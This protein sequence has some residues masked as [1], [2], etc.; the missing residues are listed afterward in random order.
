MVKYSSKGIWFSA[1]SSI[2]YMYI[3][4]ICLNG[5]ICQQIYN[6][7]NNLILLKCIVIFFILIKTHNYKKKNII[8]YDNNRNFFNNKMTFKIKLKYKFH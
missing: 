5:T 6:Y 3:V 7:E 2:R 1:N 4:Y 8:K